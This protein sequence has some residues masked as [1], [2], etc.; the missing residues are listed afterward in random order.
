MAFRLPRLPSTEPLWPVFQRW[1]Q[2]V[3][4]A[5]EGQE[6]AQDTTIA[7][8]K[9]CLSHT[10]PTTIFTATE[11]GTTATITVAAHTRVYGDGTVL[12]IAGGVQAGL[13]CDTLYAGYYDDLTLAEPSPTIVFTTD[14]PSAQAVAADGRHFIGMIRTPPAASGETREGGGVYPMGS[15]VGGELD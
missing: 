10:N 15:N 8:L 12:A 11:N 6:T 4:E 3:V 14:L 5:I 13:V 1:W 9:R 2:S 7:R